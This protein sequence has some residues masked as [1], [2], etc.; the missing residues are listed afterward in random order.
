MEED[1]KKQ[2]EELKDLN[3][4]LVAPPDPVQIRTEQA[5]GL[6]ASAMPAVEVQSLCQQDEEGYGHGV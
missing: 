1:K 3:P 2:A 6:S 5:Q 4:H